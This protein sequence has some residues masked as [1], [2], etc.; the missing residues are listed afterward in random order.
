[1]CTWP[2]Y[3]YFHNIYDIPHRLVVWYKAIRGQAVPGDNSAAVGIDV[4]LRE[5]QKI[6]PDA[7]IIIIIYDDNTKRAVVMHTRKRTRRARER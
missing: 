4:I 2:T 6:G 3:Y 5:E 7:I 1:V